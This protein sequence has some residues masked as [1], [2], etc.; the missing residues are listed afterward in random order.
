[1]RTR[2]AAMKTKTMATLG[3]IAAG[4]AA[5][6]MLVPAAGASSAAPKPNGDSIKVHGRWTIT[7]RDR[8]G[9]VVSTRRFENSLV[10]IG[11][12]HLI[13]L[14]FGVSVA[15]AYGAGWE[16]LW[17][18]KDAG[19][20]GKT[21]DAVPISRVG[22]ITPTGWNEAPQQTANIDMVGSVKATT[23]TQLLAVGTS[24]ETCSG[25]TYTAKTCSRPVSNNINFTCKV[26]DSP[27]SVA[28]GQTVDFTVVL[29]FS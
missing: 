11:Q 8:S 6:T 25:Q 22:H 21:T 13:D 26:L 2:R 24:I 17:V 1:M 7:V 16:L 20:P 15:P 5:A 29:Y 14:L 4:V 27:L 19:S 28:A 3:V 12:T 23:A 9:H 10:G 18:H